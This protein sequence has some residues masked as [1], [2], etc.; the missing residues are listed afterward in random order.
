[1]FLY[2]E[3]WEIFILYFKQAGTNKLDLRSTFDLNKTNLNPNKDGIQIQVGAEL[4]QAQV[5]L[6][7]PTIW[8]KLT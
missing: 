4:C 3:K 1:M 6:D 8:G 2:S 5:K 7:E